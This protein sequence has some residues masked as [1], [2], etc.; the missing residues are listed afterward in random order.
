MQEHLVSGSLPTWLLVA[1][2]GGLGTLLRY[3]LGGLLARVTGGVYPWE[4][5]F[6]NVLG[7]LVIGVIA[8]AVDRGLDLQASWRIAITVGLVGGFTTFST[9]ALEG[10]RLAED[11]QWAPAAIYVLITNVVGFIAVL[12]GYRAGPP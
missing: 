8:G 3:V 1:V 11:A 9:F 6:I 7:C 4:T 5:F 12:A 10:F 2:A